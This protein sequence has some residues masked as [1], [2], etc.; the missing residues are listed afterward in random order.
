ME[1]SDSLGTREFADGFRSQ[2]MT[3][4]PSLAYMRDMA[5]PRPEEEPVTT[6]TLLKSLPAMVDG[7]FGGVKQ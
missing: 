7:S 4:A 6:A 5:R 1:K 2:Q 3:E